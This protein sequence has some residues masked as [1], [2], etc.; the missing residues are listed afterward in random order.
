MPSQ[1]TLQDVANKS[2]VHRTTVS[3]ALRDHPRIPPTTRERIK[4]V[5]ARLGYRINP[6]VSALMQTRRTGRADR[7]V[8]LAYVTNY[9]TRYG[10]RPNHHDRPDFFP[11]AAERARQRGYKLEDF[12]LAEPGMTPARFCRIL[13][14]RGINGLLIGRLPPGQRSLEL[15]W[16]HFSCVALGLTLCSPILHHVTENHFDT[17]SQAMLRCHERGYRRVGFVYSD[18]NDS[19]SVGDRWLGAFLLHQSRC[20]RACRIPVCPGEPTDETTFGRW[21]NRHRPDGIIANHARPVLPWLDR[22]QVEVPRNLGLVDLDNHSS[23]DCAGVRYDP[24]E[25][26]ALAVDMLVGMLHRNET[27]I[28]QNNQHEVLLTGVWHDGQTLPPRI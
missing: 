12:W 19:P 26:G 11:G 16:N 2:G 28:P 17:V 5:A 25:V 7:H 22:L 23:L 3:L 21:F 20:S 1:A 24:Q 10:W 15:E 27:G 18:S 13:S 6:L 14:S 8:T 4:A 9:P